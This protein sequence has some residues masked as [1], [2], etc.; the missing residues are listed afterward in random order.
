MHQI[1]A[2][3]GHNQTAAGG[4]NHQEDSQQSPFHGASCHLHH[5]HVIGNRHCGVENR[6]AYIVGNKYEYVFQHVRS[7]LRNHKYEHTAECVRNAAPEQPFSRLSEFRRLR[8][9]DDISHRQ[10]GDAVKYSGYKHD[11]TDDPCA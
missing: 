7:I 11:G 9:V 8:M 3:A 1:Q 10:I 6:V 4:K 5:Q 2:G